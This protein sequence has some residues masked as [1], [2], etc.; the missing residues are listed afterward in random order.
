[1]V[2]PRFIGRSLDC[3]KPGGLEATERSTR[4]RLVKQAP[5]LHWLRPTIYASHSS[6]ASNLSSWMTRVGRAP[7]RANR[8]QKIVCTLV[9]MWS[10]PKPRRVHSVK[11]SIVGP[12]KQEYYGPSAVVPQRAP[13]LLSNLPCGRLQR[14]RPR[15]KDRANIGRRDLRR[16]VCGGKLLAR[17]R[18]DVAGP[19]LPD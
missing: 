12:K 7:G 13:S 6:I 18:G 9:S 10:P 5:R 19:P 17:R 8:I 1:M 2:G 3:D 14:R 16:K 15:K 11:P 4:C